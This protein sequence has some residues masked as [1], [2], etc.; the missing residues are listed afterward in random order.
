MKKHYRIYIDGCVLTEGYC[1]PEALDV[2]FDIYESCHPGH[3]MT[4]EEID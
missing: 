3:E 4:F 1:E 2:L